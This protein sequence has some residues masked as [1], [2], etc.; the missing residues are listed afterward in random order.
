VS[1][2]TTGDVSSRSVNVARRDAAPHKLVAAN[3]SPV[4]FGGALD[5]IECKTLVIWIGLHR[6]LACHLTPSTHALRR[7]SKVA[8]VFPGGL[9]MGKAGRAQDHSGF[10]RNSLQLRSILLVMAREWMHAAM[11]ESEERRTL[12]RNAF[13]RR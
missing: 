6:G 11:Q 2:R 9:W 13:R 10:A 4:Q 5:A 1:G 8:G 3:I 12:R 7:S